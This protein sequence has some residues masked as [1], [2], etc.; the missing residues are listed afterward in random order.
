[1]KNTIFFLIICLAYTAPGQEY[2]QQDVNYNI[3]VT[4]DDK[5]HTLTG[6]ISIDYTNNSQSNL[7]EIWFHLWPNAYKN[8][9]T[10]LAQQKLEEG[11]TDYYYANETERGFIDQIDF[12]VNDKKINL[13]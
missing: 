1:M 4:L 11:D 13:E 6:V 7:K 12:N 9:S 2:F 5:N 10:A 3:E 8:N